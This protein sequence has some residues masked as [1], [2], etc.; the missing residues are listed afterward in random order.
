MRAFVAA[1]IAVG[2]SVSLV[3]CSDNKQPQTTTTTSTT[4][5]STT[6]SSSIPSG[7]PPELKLTTIATLNQPVA[8]GQRDGDGALYV[9]EKAGTVRAVRNGALV[10]KPALDISD[11]VGSQ[12]SE[13]GLL[14]IAFAPDSSNLYLNYT[15]KSGDTR[16][17]EF[18]MDKDG[19]I[20]P[21]TRREL[22]FIDQP[23]ENH[24][25]GQLGFGPDGLLYIGMGDGGSRGDPQKNG[26]NL[27]VL[28]GKILRINPKSS[29]NLPYTIPFDNPFTKLTGAR[30]EIWSY[31]LRNPW[32]FSFDTQDKSL[33]IADV[34]QNSYE[35]INHVDEDP[36]GGQNYGWALRE[37]T[38]KFT[39]NKPKDAIEPVYEYETG[40]NGDCSVTGGYVY[41][42]NSIPKMSARYVFGDYCSG[43]ILTLTEQDNQW[44]AHTTNIKVANLSSFGQDHNGE[45]YTLS[46]S[47]DLSRIDTV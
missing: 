10:E 24:N 33:W 19:N 7:P 37:G 45:I 3:A 42:G 21:A 18:V 20:D 25:G 28:L 2:L 32:R 16:I 12:G 43:K 4:Q 46:L 1:S 34:G 41:R 29:G 13:Q 30:G 5:Q 47:G 14:G 11:L 23:F 35:E 9:A 8:M 22:L 40:E 38:H 26:Q 31:G 15:D 17:A 6:T 44:Q 39:G 27:T 36:K